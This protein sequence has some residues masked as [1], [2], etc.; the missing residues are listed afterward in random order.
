MEGKSEDVESVDEGIDDGRGESVSGVSPRWAY[1]REGMER[2]SFDGPASAAA[3]GAERDGDAVAV[4]VA[5]AG[6]LP[7]PWLA[8]AS[9]CS[10]CQFYIGGSSCITATW[11]GL[12]R[13]QDA[14]L[15]LRI[16]IHK[17]RVRL[18]AFP[19]RLR[20]AEGGDL[21]FEVFFDE[22]G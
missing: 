16:G 15:P 22:E 9:A 13:R 6:E 2:G 1:G 12:T 14:D 20:F 11:T 8:D 3:A 5:K 10:V 17:R 4:V 7:V 18:V 19:A 21:G